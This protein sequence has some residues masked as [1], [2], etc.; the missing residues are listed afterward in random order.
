MR[1]GLILLALLTSTVQA[2]IYKTHDKNGNVV[3]T[4]AK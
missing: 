1:Y 4:D 3:F 2:G